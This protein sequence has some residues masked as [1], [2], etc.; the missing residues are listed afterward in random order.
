M[1]HRKSLVILII[2]IG[3]VLFSLYLVYEE[4]R[5]AGY[6]P[7]FFQIPACYLVLGGFLLVLLSC[8]SHTRALSHALFFLGTSIGF[9]LAAWFSYHQLNGL[10]ICPELFRIPLC[11][12]SFFV[13]LTLFFIKA[14]NGKRNGVGPSYLFYFQ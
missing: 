1:N 13:F 2:A 7:R 12:V 11:Y 8:F 10:K 5:Q 4:I 6:C 3:G 9:I 14:R